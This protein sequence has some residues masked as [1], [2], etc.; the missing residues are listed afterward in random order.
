MSIILVRPGNDKT[1]KKI[2]IVYAS[3]MPEKRVRKE[4]ATRT[5]RLSHWSLNVTAPLLNKVFPLYVLNHFSDS[6]PE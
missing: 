4:H 6:K 1:E 2:I 3:N 5:I